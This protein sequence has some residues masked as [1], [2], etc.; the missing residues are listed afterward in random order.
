MDDKERIPAN[1][2]IAEYMDYFGESIRHSKRLNIPY[3]WEEDHVEINCLTYHSS[4][5]ALAPV[6][7]KI[8]KIRAI[9]SETNEDMWGVYSSFKIPIGYSKMYYYLPT[10]DLILQNKNNQEAAEMYFEKFNPQ[11]E[12]V[13][14]KIIA[15][16][17]TIVDYLTLLKSQEAKKQKM[18]TT[19]FPSTIKTPIKLKPG[20]FKDQIGPNEKVFALSWRQ[21]FLSLM[22]PPHDKIETRTW[23]TT[24]RGWVLM[25]ASQKPYEQG[26]LFGICGHNQLA[27]INQAL[28]G[29]DLSSTYGKAIMV[30]RI[31]D[32]R[33]MHKNDQDRC[34]VQ[35]YPDLFAHVYIDVYAIKPLPWKGQLSW[36]EV[37]DDVLSQIIIL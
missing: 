30:G 37:T 18:Q 4:W 17:K 28:K 14:S 22:P 2:L 32:S 1:K 33:P 5:E 24:K 21:P 12:I 34:F 19:I 35:Y 15:V 16:W 29:I 23:D 13:S 11:R 6:V 36:K 3:N 7:E 10:E 20:S 9:V 8:N 31:V 27:R 25:C 26:K